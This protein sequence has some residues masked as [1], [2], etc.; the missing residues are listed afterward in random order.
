M[1]ADEKQLGALV[2]VYGIA[3]ASLQ[4]AAIVAIVSFLFFLLML[5]VF[6]LR[7]NVGY[8]LLATAFLIV[9][10]FTLFGF[11]SAKRLVFKEFVNGFTYKKH[12][13]RWDEIESIDVREENK[14]IGGAK[15]N[16]EIKKT[17]GEKIVLTEAIYGIE[18]IVK[19][20]RAEIGDNFELNG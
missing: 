19:K 11:F 4:R 2:A 3:P 14:L 13:C 15:I 10:L 5:V 12:V 17:T 9:Q 16:C 20:V 7:Q 6:S 18:T 8:F 1:S